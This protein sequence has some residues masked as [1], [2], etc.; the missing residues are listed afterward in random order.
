MKSIPFL[1]LSIGAFYLV[2][3]ASP[4]AERLPA[5]PRLRSA[6]RE[7]IGPEKKI[8]ETG[9]DLRN[10]RWIR[11]N[12]ER[13]ERVPFDGI[14]LRPAVFR[15][16]EWQTQL[17]ELFQ[18]GRYNYAELEPA[19]ADLRATRFR[20]FRFNF[21]LTNVTPGGVDWFDDDFAAVVHNWRVA[22]RFAA[23]GGLRGILFDPEPY[24]GAMWVYRQQKYAATKG[25]DEYAEQAFRRGQEVMRAVNEEYPDIHL[26]MYFGPSMAADAARLGQLAEHG[27]GLFPAFV[28]GM[29]SVCTPGTKII[30][31]HEQAYGYST[32][33][34]FRYGY[35]QMREEAVKYSRVPEQ[36]RR[37]LSAGFGLWPDRAWRGSGW[38]VDDPER[39][40][41]PPDRWELILHTALATCDEYVWVYSEALDWWT[42]KN[43]PW[44]YYYAILNAR[45]PHTWPPMEQGDGQPPPIKAADQQGYDDESTF[46]QLLQTHDLLGDLP[47]VW[48]FRLDPE[49]VGEAQRWFAADLDESGWQDI[50]IGRFWEEQGWDYDGVAWYRV[51]FDVPPEAAGRTLFLAIGAADESGWVW[52]NGQKAGEQ[53]RGEA[54]W[55]QL[56]LVP[57]N[58]LRPGQSNTVAIRVLDRNR[59]GGLWKS[60]KL[61]AER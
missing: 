2:P 33:A 42:G 35:R 18:T 7:A 51:T 56:F 11:E 32:A 23:Q 58:A 3:P 9:W 38:H 34:A 45:A 29:L 40:D 6:E 50:E 46:G 1:S 36:F 25:F 37:H 59:V 4:A 13:M 15:N 17:L 53:D 54:G 28:D 61:V 21:V 39:N 22:A 44:P 57:A 55:D 8:I 19:V 47:K 41:P 5:L 26:L 10:T 49:D 60:V 12:I 20:R 27:Y 48:Q 31:G 24:S 30:D 14:V 52:I 16:G 43:I